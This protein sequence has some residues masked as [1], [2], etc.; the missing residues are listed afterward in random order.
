[1]AVQGSHVET[2]VMEIFLRVFYTLRASLPIFIQL[3]RRN[4][5]MPVKI[6]ICFSICQNFAKFQ[7]PNTGNLGEAS[8]ADY[9]Q[10]SHSMSP[11]QRRLSFLEKSELWVFPKG[12]LKSLY[13][14]WNQRFDYLPRTEERKYLQM[15]E[16]V[17]IYQWIILSRVFAQYYVSSS[18]LPLFLYRSLCHFLKISSLES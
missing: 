12:K 11:S 7:G 3:E 8:L 9:T 14:K 2:N 1:M 18:F 15:R 16:Q 6:P 17:N 5:I 13:G 10:Q 4:G